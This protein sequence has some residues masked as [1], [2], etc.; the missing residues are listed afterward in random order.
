M[1][2]RLKN[3]FN[4]LTLPNILDDYWL[5]LVLF[6]INLF[7][8][9]AIFFPIMSDIN[10]W[11][12]AV[13]VHSGQELVEGGEIPKLSGNPLTSLFLGITYFPF[14]NSTFWMLKSISL[15]RILLF[16]LIWW[17]TYLVA[18]ELR[19][20]S[21]P[22]IPLGILFVTPLSIEMLRFPTDPLFASFSA[23]SLW[24]LLRYKQTNERRNLANASFFMAL[25][26]LARVD[27]L[28]QFAILF[29]LG[30]VININRRKWFRTIVAILVPFAAIV[31]GL[32]LIRG[33]ATGDYGTGI[34]ERTYTNFESGQQV[35]FGGTGELNAVV[36]SR[37]EARR[38]F[39]T[40]QEN[41][42]SPFKA[43]ARN[44][45]V[46]VQRLIGSLK[47]LPSKLLHAYGIRFAALLLYLVIRGAIELI[48]EKKYV[49]L[50]IFSLWPTHLASGL[51][52]TIFRTGHL[53]FSFYIV[54]VLAA[55]GLWA[56]RKN[57]NNKLEISL[58]G[59]YLAALSLYGLVDNKLAI[60]Y[61]A[62]T[63]LGIL[64]LFVFLKRSIP[65]RNATALLILLCGGL[66]IRGEFP[67]P[68]L[69]NLGDDPKEKSIQFL[70]ENFEPGT[71]IAAGSPGVVMASKMRYAG[72]NAADV[73]TD[74][75][76][77]E[78]KDWLQVQDIEVVYIDHSLYQ[79]APKIWQLIEPLIGGGYERLFETE[80]GNYQILR[81]DS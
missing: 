76:P 26:A 16:C 38:L 46:Y 32:I 49:T 35:I 14:R 73:P 25:A 1:L 80:Q 69:R 58:L 57:F 23:F 45:E 30:M 70:V 75:S 51:V 66:I 55:I 27:G 64:L 40:A 67:S 9:Y 22:I 65:I 62:A 12:E 74:V 3:W 18:K 68:I 44:P 36:E 54:F 10:P 8:V 72:L 24:Q 60:F 17:S 53:Q 21:P 79:D 6:L 47:A 20:L 28:A 63:F 41:D 56:I 2:E 7:L 50:T 71:S 29:F 5:A 19:D 31:G 48:R 11:D 59:A 39:G 13:F 43:I 78:F 52:I 61:G 33:L 15:A 34:P 42:N 37:I 77:M 81:I 4:R